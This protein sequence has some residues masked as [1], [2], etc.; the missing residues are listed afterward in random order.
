MSVFELRRA[1]IAPPVLWTRGQGCGEL[2]ALLSDGD[3]VRV[4]GDLVEECIRHRARL[5]VTR[6]LTDLDLVS[7]VVPIDF[8]PDGVSAVV[9]AV[10]G[11]PHSPLAARIARRLGEALG[12]DALM[13]CAYRDEESR[14]RAVSL[15]EHLYQDVPELEY[16]VVEATD[17]SGLVAQLPDRSMLVLGAPGGNWFQRTIFGQGARLRQRAPA[18]A[19]VVRSAPTRV[20][21]VMTDPVFVG[22]LREAGDILRVHSEEVLAVVD[23]ARLV[24]VVDRQVLEDAEPHTP[25]SALMV[26]PEAV[27]LDAPLSDA[28]PL[29][30]RF[31]SAPVPV[32]DEDGMLV[33]AVIPA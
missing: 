18:G 21:Q 32:V 9:A 10:A 27:L 3:P 24:G 1:G 26:D 6:R 8:D 7:Q 5:L 2:A 28:L 23:R 20:F 12:L 14:E 15:I 4:K 13:A 29:A 19:V 25:V 11:G 22:P 33:G 16:R 31:R 30:D 17:A